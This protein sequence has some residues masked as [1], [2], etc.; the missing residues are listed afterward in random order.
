[1]F[2]QKIKAYMHICVYVCIYV[3]VDIYTYIHKGGRWGACII[4]KP[5]SRKLY[6]RDF[7]QGYYVH[8]CIHTHMGAFFQLIA[9]LDEGKGARIEDLLRSLPAESFKHFFPRIY[10]TNLQ[11]IVCAILHPLDLVYYEYFPKSLNRL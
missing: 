1:M 7:S 3:H 2:I 5:S 4:Y 11:P 10:F 9:G 8:M 6:T